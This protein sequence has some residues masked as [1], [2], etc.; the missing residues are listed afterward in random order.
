MEATKVNSNLK[1]IG[2]LLLA[3]LIG[4]L[5]AVAVKW[6]G[7]NYSVLEIVTFRSLVAL[8]IT[9]LFFRLEGGK[10]LPTTSQPK[11]QVV[12]GIFLFLSY[13]TFMMGLAALPLADV[14]AIRFSGPMMITILSVFMLSEKVELRRWLALIVGFAGI[15]LIVKPGSTNFNEGSLFVLISVLFY[16]LTVILTRKMNAT[17]SSATMAYFSSWVYLIAAFIFSPLAAAVGE[18]PNAHPSVAFLFHAWTMPTPL[19]LFIMSGLG[20]VWALWAYFMTRAYST[21]QASVIAP[22]EYA[23]LP[24]SIMWGFL[25]WREVPTLLTLAGAALTLASGMYLLVQDQKQKKVNQIIADNA[26]LE[27]E[28]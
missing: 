14:E 10:G 24:I 15:L 20:L 1:G 6:I 23:S 2:F 18:I 17:D 27:N 4:S 3:M 25:F 21:A 19:D 26:V 16:A 8:P 11:L 28:A 7:G 5:Q 12:R 22:F 9:L 13:T